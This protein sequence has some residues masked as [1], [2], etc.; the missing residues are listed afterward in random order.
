MATTHRFEG[1]LSCRA[2][3]TGVA[4]ANSTSTFDGRPPL[5]LSSA[6]AYRGDP[7]RLSPEDLFGAALAS[8]QRMTDVALRPRITV[9][10][11]TDGVQ[12]RAAVHAGHDACFIA[13][14]AT[15]TVS[16]EPDIAAD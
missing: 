12:V 2:G 8:C 1:T 6:P 13:N 10:R 11:D 15:S 5:L 7:A 3:G 9:A 16:V 4:A 14:S